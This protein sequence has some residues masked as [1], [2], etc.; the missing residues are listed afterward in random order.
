MGDMANW[1]TSI[2]GIAAAAVACGGAVRA[3]LG[4]KAPWNNLPLVVYVLLSCVGLSAVA[5]YV[6]NVQ[7]APTF[8]Q[9]LVMAGTACIVAVGGV[10]FATNVLKP[11][12]DTVD[13]GRLGV[14]LL[15]GVLAATSVACASRADGTAVSPEG[16]LALRANQFVQ[17]LRVTV[18]PPGASPIEQL[19]ASKVIT[20]N[21]GIQVASA[22]K[23]AMQGGQDLA[24]AL[25][26]VDNAKTAS[27]RQA[28]LARAA[29]LVQ[30]IA[31]GLDTAKI[32]VLTP[33]GRAAVVTVLQSA[34]SL[35]LTVGSLF[36]APAPGSPGGAAFAFGGAAEHAAF[37]AAFAQ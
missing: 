37:A 31:R 33:E 28:G 20:A 8:A 35:L 32:R 23:V 27:E 12:A 2:A 25:Q 13:K 15:A 29:A 16:T 18:Q 3:W 11:L 26:L 17:A 4:D 10:S 34:S 1:Y 21:D 9:L 36:P 5:Q 7:L 19:V 30:S 14:L 24:A 22:V 6:M